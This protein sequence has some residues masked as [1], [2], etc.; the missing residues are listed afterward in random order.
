MMKKLYIS[1]DNYKNIHKTPQ[2]ASK[3]YDQLTKIILN[4]YKNMSNFTHTCKS[5]KASVSQL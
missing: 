3:T 4:I 1:D 5:K 2:K